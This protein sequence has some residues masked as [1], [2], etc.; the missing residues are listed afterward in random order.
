MEENYQQIEQ[1]Q[2]AEYNDAE[3]CITQEKEVCIKLMFV[4]G[5]VHAY[6]GNAKEGRQSYSV[7][8]SGNTAERG[9]FWQLLLS[10]YQDI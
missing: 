7:I 2:N 8:A 3:Q 6:T 5:D 4:A 1:Q 10:I 9:G